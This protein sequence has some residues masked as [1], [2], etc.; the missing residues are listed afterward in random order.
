MTDTMKPSRG[1]RAEVGATPS[2][3]RPCDDLMDLTSIAKLADT[4]PGTVRSWRYR[5]ADF[6]VPTQ[7]NVGPVW[8]RADIEAWLA[9]RK[10]K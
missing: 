3:S 10:K 1:D 9:S 6:P 5:H 4:T 2:R 7:L 8:Q